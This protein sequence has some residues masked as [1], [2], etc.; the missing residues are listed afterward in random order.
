MSARR[1]PGPDRGAAVSFDGAAESYAAARPSYPQALFESVLAGLPADGRILEIGAGSG[2]ASVALASRGHQVLCLE[3]GG[4]LAAAAVRALASR[5]RARVVPTTFEAW[6][7]ERAAFDLVF[8]AQAFHWIDPAVGLGKCAE[9]LRDGGTAAFVW[10]VPEPEASLRAALDRAYRRFAPELAGRW[11][12]RPF[13]PFLDG[14]G[15][16]L[17]A[18]PA[19]GGAA[20]ERFPWSARYDAARWRRLLETFSDHRIEPAERRRALLD[21]VAA[22]IDAI[23]GAF[24]LRYVAVLH[25]ARRR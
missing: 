7:L 15:A 1:G 2:Q 25:R 20:V 4:R 6:P 9:A 23:G 19:F 5:P 13:A 17:A 22:E 16:A 8:A 3:P 11:H 12:R 18:S 21:A 24:E 10:N 14:F